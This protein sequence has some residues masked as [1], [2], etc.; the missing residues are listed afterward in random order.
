VLVKT[1][2]YLERLPRVVHE[3]GSAARGEIEILVEPIEVLAAAQERVQKLGVV[4]VGPD[5][6]GIVFEDE[7]LT[8]VRDAVRFPNG[9]LGTYVRIFE[10]AALIA[11]ENGVVLLPVRDNHLIL[12]RIFRHATRCWELEA[13]RGMLDVG[14]D[15]LTAAERELDEELGIPARAIIPVGVMTP[16]SGLLV[17]FTSVYVAHLT[18]GPSRDQPENSEAFGEIV[19]IPFEQVLTLVA[20]GDLRDAHT[21]SAIMMGIAAGCLDP[22]RIITVSQI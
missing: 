8:V 11:G 18:K 17:G 13:P 15:G 14:E 5:D 10:R 6:I 19:S 12:R 3:L 7:Y 9:T 22:T 1:N 4:A 2:N 16:N 20:K 21:L